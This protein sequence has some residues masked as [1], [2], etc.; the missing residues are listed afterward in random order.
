[1]RRRTLRQYD[2]RDGRAADSSA[3]VRYRFRTA[4]VDARGHDIELPGVPKPQVFVAALG[5][6]AKEVSVK[7]LAEL[8]QAGVATETDYTGRSLKAQ[9]K[10]A[11]KYDAKIVLIIGEDE[12]SQGVVTLRDML[13]KEQRQI[14]I[15]QVLSTVKDL[16]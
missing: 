16:L 5:T 13:S 10:L 3:W 9:M 8:R 4:S 6:A 11:D 12:V 7:L 2:R 1:M 15:K 14:P